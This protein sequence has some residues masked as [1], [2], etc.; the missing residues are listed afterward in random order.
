M[1]LDDKEKLLDIRKRT[2][3]GKSVTKEEH[4]FCIT[5][6]E[7]DPEGYKEVEQKLYNWINNASWWE[8]L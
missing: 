1:T 6:F 8:L 3:T 2:K 4:E 7:K 5:C